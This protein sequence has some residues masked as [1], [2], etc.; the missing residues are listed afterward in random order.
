VSIDDVALVVF[1]E[2]DSV[3]P[4]EVSVAD[5]E[6]APLKFWREIVTVYCVVELR[7]ID[8]DDGLTEIPKSPVCVGWT[9]SVAGALWF[10]GPV[11]VTENP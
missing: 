10:G 6:T 11:P 5:S 9:T 4:D 3:R 1:G 2:N 7:P 8:A